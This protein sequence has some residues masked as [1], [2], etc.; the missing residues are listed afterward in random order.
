MEVSLNVS[1]LEGV[2]EALSRFD[3]EMIAQVHAKLVEWCNTVKT[4]AQAAAPVRTSYL[5][6]HI[7]A[8]VNDWVGSLGSEAAYSIFVEFG[9]RY[10]KARP[11]LFPALQAQLPQLETILIEAINLAKEATGL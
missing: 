5:R 9:T 1:G 6:D 4:L 7:Y 2:Q 10:M 11:F 8:E 3:A